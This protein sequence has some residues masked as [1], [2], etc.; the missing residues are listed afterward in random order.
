MRNIIITVSMV[1]IS[2]QVIQACA[3]LSGG[4]SSGKH[5]NKSYTMVQQTN[6]NEVMAQIDRA[7]WVQLRKATNSQEVRLYATLG[8]KEWEVAEKDARSYLSTNPKNKTALIVLA[9]SLAM[10]KNYALAAY[11]G[12]LLNRYHPGFSEAKNL[13]GLATLN[14][15]SAGYT[16]Y[17]KAA[18]YFAQAFDGSDTQ[19]ASGLNLG[20]LYLQL[21]NAKSAVDV[22]GAVRQRCGDCM[23]SLVGFAIA[24][25]RTRDFKAAKDAFAKVLDKDKNHPG[26]LYYLA[27]IEN[28]GQKRPDKAIALLTRLVK[29]TSQRDMNIKR[30]GNALLRRLQA[31][32]YAKQEKSNRPLPDFDGANE[33]IPV[34][35]KP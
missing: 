3:S 34:S 18:D 14:R 24:S 13:M 6:G 23:E 5:A 8:A 22:F 33:L 31:N 20:H 28:Y 25:S 1:I 27:L 32:E 35:D 2:T 30:K 4:R 15:P 26:S 12:S 17:K 9:T 19:I 16:D 11:Y 7:S 10:Q 29:D 21:G